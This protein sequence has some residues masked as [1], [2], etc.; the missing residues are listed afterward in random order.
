M[1]E[2]PSS[3]VFQSRLQKNLSGLRVPARCC[4]VGMMPRKITSTVCAE[5][6]ERQGKEENI[7]IKKKGKYCV[8][9]AMVTL[10]RRIQ[11][12]VLSFYLSGTLN[13]LKPTISSIVIP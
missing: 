7:F 11:F 8:N 2:S 12:T 5:S 6:A 10:K 13:L 3:D 1:M 4:R 9:G